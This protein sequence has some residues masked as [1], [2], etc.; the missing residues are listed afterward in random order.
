[1]LFQIDSFYDLVL[2]VV[3]FF[4]QS[5][6]YLFTTILKK[7]QVFPAWLAPNLITFSGF[8]LVVF[9]F[10]LLTYFDPDFYASGENFIILMHNFKCLE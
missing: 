7:K 4:E 3:M 2:Y 6:I 5:F 9:N 8:M 1:M 10:L